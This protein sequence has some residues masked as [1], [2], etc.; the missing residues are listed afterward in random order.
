MEDF[1]ATSGWFCGRSWGF[2]SLHVCFELIFHHGDWAVGQGVM[3]WEY[4]EPQPLP[5]C[6]GEQCW[7]Q[8]LC[9]VWCDSVWLLLFFLSSLSSSIFCSLRSELIL[10]YCCQKCLHFHCH[11]ASV[12]AQTLEHLSWKS[13]NSTKV[14]YN[15]LYMNPSVLNFLNWC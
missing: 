15:L 4:L 1:V 6:W 12:A 7:M 9:G 14:I 11:W 10:L 8:D 2:P 5:V 3:F 13:Q